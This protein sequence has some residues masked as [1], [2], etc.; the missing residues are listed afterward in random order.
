MPVIRADR[1]PGKMLRGLARRTLS[2][3]M[4]DLKTAAADGGVHGVRK[5]LKFTRSLLRLVRYSIGRRDFASADR[6]LRKAADGLAGARRAEAL[7]ETVSKLQAEISLPKNALAELGAAIARAHDQYATGQSMRDA[8]P[9]AM[10]NMAS[11][12]RA[13]SRWPLA[14]RSIDRLVKGLKMSYGRARRKLA[15]GLS[16]GEIAILHEARKSVIHHLHQLEILQPLSPGMI[17]ARTRELPILREALGD[18]NDLDELEAVIAQ[19]N[20]TAFSSIAEQDSVTA[21][22]AARRKVLMDLV[23]ERSDHLF[24]E[25]PKAFANRIGSMWKEKPD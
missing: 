9:K 2:A 11:V 7:R 20:V 13:V 12:H 17:E 19:E 15:E 22:I 4:K 3:A 5:R 16:S 6:R 24:S 14:S 1:P 10:R 21:A 8:M 23:R 25:Q 18:L